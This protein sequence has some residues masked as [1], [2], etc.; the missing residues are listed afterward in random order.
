MRLRLMQR[1]DCSNRACTAVSAEP[2]RGIR[3]EF[4]CFPDQT[5]K[6]HAG[7][8]KEGQRHSEEKT[9]LKERRHARGSFRYFVGWKRVMLGLRGLSN[10]GDYMPALHPAQIASQWKSKILGLREQGGGILPSLY[11]TPDRA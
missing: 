4:V 5:A 8:D 6:R 9:R 3:T 10:T 11:T 2:H 1:N 7:H